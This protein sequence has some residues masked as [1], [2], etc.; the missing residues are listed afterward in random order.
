MANCTHRLLYPSPLGV[1]QLTVEGTALTALRLCGGSEGGEPRAEVAH[2]N[3]QLPATTP[4][5]PTAP[6]AAR[7]L[8]APVVGWLDAYFA[9]REP[10]GLPPMLLH[11]TPFQQRVWHELLRVPY[12]HTITYGELAR[13]LGCRSAQAVGQA[14]GRNPI[15]IIVP[16]HRV[17]A[18]NGLGGYAYGLEVKQ[19]LLSL[20]RE[21]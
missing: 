2:A 9:G 7:P 11:G 16:C 15:A 5:L 14:V 13:R 18:S 20:E 17:V 12:G 6:P 10:D 19:R 21:L 1:L 4:T 8:F 3:P